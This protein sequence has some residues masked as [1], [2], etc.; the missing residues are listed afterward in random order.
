M[1]SLLPTTVTQM[2]DVLTAALKNVAEVMEEGYEGA[3]ILGVHFEGPYLD[4]DYKAPSR[5]RRSRRH[6]WPSSRNTRRRQR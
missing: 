1:T 3:E 5:R 2:P 4:M 6:P